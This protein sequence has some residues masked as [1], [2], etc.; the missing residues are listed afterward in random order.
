M[1]SPLT[2]PARAFACHEQT[3]RELAEELGLDAPPSSSTT[4]GG[5]GSSSFFASILQRLSY[6][7]GGGEGGGD[8][9]GKGSRG[10]EGLCGWPVSLSPRSPRGVR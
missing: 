7:M 5:G 4:K 9:G 10:E 2:R 8:G 3:N 6:S 1:D